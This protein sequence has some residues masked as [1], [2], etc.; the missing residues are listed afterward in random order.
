MTSR[1]RTQSD[2]KQKSPLQ[3]MIDL[4]D[5]RGMSFHIS[6]M[7]IGKKA[8]ILKGVRITSNVMVLRPTR[9]RE[10]IHR[11][12]GDENGPG[13]L[14]DGD[15]PADE[16]TGEPLEDIQKEQDPEGMFDV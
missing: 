3:Q 1:I 5:E 4:V 13:D 14:E 6:S 8:T 15:N 11:E 12:A 7:T 16:D 10:R 9:T 2:D